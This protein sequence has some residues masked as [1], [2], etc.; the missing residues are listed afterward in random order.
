MFFHLNKFK[1]VIRFKKGF[2]RSMNLLH[3]GSLNMER[4]FVNNSH[5]NNLS[6]IS[7][8]FA[9]FVLLLTPN[10]QIL[11][12]LI[13][14]VVLP[15]TIIHELFHLSVITLFFP[16]IESSFDL[17]LFTSS[18]TIFA[19]ITIEELPV[20]WESVVTMLFGTL[21][22]ICVISGCLSYLKN[23]TSSHYL[24]LRNFLIFGLLS[25]IPNLFPIR[26]SMINAVSDG[27]SA[28]IMLLRM[29]FPVYPSLPI[30]ALFYGLTAI[31]VFSSFFYLGSAFYHLG[32]SLKLNLSR[33]TVIDTINNRVNDL[34]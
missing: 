2:N 28:S 16:M 34:V 13:N 23:Q 33:I 26:P 1:I 25:D 22:V 31:L 5:I 8:C 9:F 3:T 19:K 17:N 29:G 18:T 10:Y 15:F 4:N 12:I 24:A 11:Q 6:S 27:Y 21:G 14:I 7:F 30:S 32:F 20:C